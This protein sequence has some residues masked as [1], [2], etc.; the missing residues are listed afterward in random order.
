MRTMAIARFLHLT[1]PIP[2]HMFH[3]TL[4]WLVTRLLFTR[5]RTFQQVMQ[6][7]ILMFLTTFQCT[8]KPFHMLI[9]DPLTCR[10]TF[11]LILR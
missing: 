2:R 7:Y 3:L 11:P 9:Q 10:D 5:Q 8:S 4:I 6:W 1:P